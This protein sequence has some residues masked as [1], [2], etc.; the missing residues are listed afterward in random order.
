MRAGTY[1][2]LH[3]AT[4]QYLSCSG[5]TLRLSSTPQPWTLQKL[6]GK[7]F[8]IYA[9]GTTLLLDI[10]N[11]WVHPG[12]TVKLWEE[13]GYNVQIWSV[14]ET[15]EGNC[16]I[17]HS[18][19]PRFCLGFAGGEAVLQRR[20]TREPA[21]E[22]KVLP[23]AVP[24]EYLSVLSRGRIVELQ[25]PT[26]IECIL[27]A[28]RLQLW[29][30]QLEIAYGIFYE[31]TGHLPYR[32]ITVEAYKTAP[33][34]GYAGWVWPNR[35]VIHIDRDFLR[36]D[37]A[38]MAA[39]K[40]DW[41]FCALHEMGHMFDFGMPWCFEAEMMTDLKVAYVMEKANASAAPFEF[42]ARVCFC[43]REIAEAYGRLA[44]DFSG[45]YHVFGCVRRFMEIR[46]RIGWDA[47][48]E[49]FHYLQEQKDRYAHYSHEEKFLLFMETLSRFSGEDLRSH[50]STAEWNTIRNHCRM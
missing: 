44:R 50:F 33:N 14:E 40:S 26:D 29:A 38:N 24:K 30:D 19:D 10:H 47:F 46:E 7:G 8:Y 37:L 43:G 41:N 17:L 20:K 36:R 2:F 22:W 27:P 6:E 5:R 34:P 11:A 15:P 13:T 45:Q 23:L 3:K 31:L 1:T 42:P 12:N 4:G 35:N 18:A 16:A 39:R 32:S 25:L 49:T 28:Q 9:H 21:Q 48:R